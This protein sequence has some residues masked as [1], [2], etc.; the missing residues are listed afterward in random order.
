VFV[1]AASSTTGIAPAAA[2]PPATAYVIQGVEGTSWSMS[3]DDEEVAASA[4]EK[5]IV[6]PFELMPGS[7][8][9][10]AVDAD[11]TEIAANL[12]VEPG[13]S[14]DVVLH[15]PVDPTADPLFTTFVNDVSAVKAGSGRLTVAHTAVAP[16]ADIR[17]DGEVLLA[18]VASTEQI[19]TV[20]PAGIY[21]VDVVP[22]SS[23]GPA[24]LGPVD[25]DV[26]PGKLTRVFAIGVAAERNMD[27]VVQV[28]PLPVTDATTPTDVPGGDGG[29]AQSLVD[30]DRPGSVVFTGLFLLACGALLALLGRRPRRP[31]RLTSRQ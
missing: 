4:P 21:P 1:L 18:D 20:V 9:I 19:T 29:Q 23:D 10:S 31:V 12:T 28:L 14:V 17:V 22:A 16:P 7:H 3:L 26:N 5:E 25:L 13:A 24:V 11:G 27:A 30:V 15:R 2:A 8:T 6:G